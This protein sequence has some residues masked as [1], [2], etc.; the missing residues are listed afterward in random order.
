MGSRMQLP[1]SSPVFDSYWK[2]AAARQQVYFA[3]VSGSPPPWTTDP[4][5]TQY[6]F[7]NA[8]RAADR[9][10]QFM[11]RSVIY[12]AQH[13]EPD[14]MFRILLFKLFNRIETW[15]LLERAFGDVTVSTFNVE[16]YAAVLNDA[17]RTGSR[18]YSAAYIMPPAPGLRRHARKHETHL[19]LLA[20]ML[21]DHLPKTLAA[22]ESLRDVY[23]LLV[24]YPGLGPF[25]AYQFAIDLNYSPLIDHSEMDF[26][27][28]G[29]GAVDGIRKCFP[30]ARPSDMADIIYK[31]CEQQEEHFAA[32]GLAFQT[33]WGRPLQLIDC[34]NLFCEIS[35]YARVAHPEIVGSTGRARIKQRFTSAG[36]L[37][38][39]SF[40]P[41]WGLCTLSPT[42]T[43]A[44]PSTGRVRDAAHR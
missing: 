6:R 35:K 18:I 12:G 13:N 9:V 38:P 2:F 16:R 44:A 36:S 34:Q 11:L 41:K 43:T 33:L 3:R 32:R 7:T 15:Q 40:P 37:P 14:L 17:L 29:P 22:T 21:S 26:V 4:I 19:A 5:I 20:S 31:V 25:L 10:S 27:Q 42:G 8:Y 1:P 23:A 28:P 30:T 24:E 39:P